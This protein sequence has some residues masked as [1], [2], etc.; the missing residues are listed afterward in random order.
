M[1][2]DV[3]TG[4]VVVDLVVIDEVVMAAAWPGAGIDVQDLR[5]RRQADDARGRSHLQALATVGTK[6]VPLAHRDSPRPR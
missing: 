2:N 1:V 4:V 5:S 3:W 6:D